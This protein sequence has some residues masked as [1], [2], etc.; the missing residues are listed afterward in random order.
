M[1][2][3]AMT[4]RATIKRDAA[5]ETDPDGHPGPSDFDTVEANVPCRVWSKMRRSVDDSGK[6]VVIEDIRGYFA[7]D[8]D[9][10][11]DDRI[12]V[13]DRLGDLLFDGLAVLTVARQGSSTSQAAHQ[14]V[15]FQ[16]HK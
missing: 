12:E 16:R 9:I 6:D 7:H 5:R 2:R 11:H 1:S 4:M 15:L 10:S 3:G 13:R 8:T 14:L